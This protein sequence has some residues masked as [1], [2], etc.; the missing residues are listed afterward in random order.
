MFK[1]ITEE[2]MGE[3]FDDEEELEKRTSFST[4]VGETKMPVDIYRQLLK[5]VKYYETDNVY[6]IR[7]KWDT[8]KEQRRMPMKVLVWIGKNSYKQMS[9]NKHLIKEMKENDPR[10]TL[11]D[12]LGEQ[13]KM[14]IGGGPSN[15]LYLNGMTLE[16]KETKES[17]G[18][19]ATE[20]EISDFRGEKIKAIHIR[21]S[22]V[23]DMFESHNARPDE[24]KEQLDMMRLD[25]RPSIIVC[26]PFNTETPI[27]QIIRTQTGGRRVEPPMPTIPGV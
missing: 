27:L 19:V 21:R 4:S 11:A 3:V 25:T 6:D 2:V 9:Q 1:D 18:T 26:T 24:V 5:N 23:T 13:P 15:T 17:G 10:Q 12:V 20:Y 16:K 22:T 8:I 14:K 7:H